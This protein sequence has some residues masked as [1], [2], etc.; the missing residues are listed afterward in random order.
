M[1]DDEPTG[2]IATG[3]IVAA[4][5]SITGDRETS[6]DIDYIA[7]YLIEGGS[8]V[9]DLLGRN[10][11][12]GTLY[13]PYLYGIYDA[14]G[15][16]VANH[17]DDG[18]IGFN[19]RI[20]FVAPETGTYYVAAGAY[21]TRTGTYTLSVSINPPVPE[22]HLADATEGTIDIGGSVTGDRETTT[23]S[24]FY[25]VNLAAGVTYSFDLEGYYTGAGT[26]RDPYIFGIYD[27][28]G[29]RIS[30]SDDDSGVGLNS[31]LLFTPSET[32]I[33]SISVGGYYYY[34]GTYTLSVDYVLPK[35]GDPFSEEPLL[36][37]G[38]SGDD[39]LVGAGNA[40]TIDG[41]DG[42][43]SLFG[44]AGGDILH[45]GNGADMLA[46]G[47]GDDILRGGSGNDILDG[48]YGN[49]LLGGGAGDDSLVSFGGTNTMW[50]GGGDDQAT[51]G[52]DDDIIG[53]GAGDDILSG[54]LRNDTLYGGAGDDSLLGGDGKDALYGGQGND[55]L[56]G[57]NDDDTLWGSMGN[58][59]LTGGDG[60]DTFVFT[61]GSGLD[62]ITDFDAENDVLML[63][64]TATDFLK[65]EDIAAVTVSFA[66]GLMINLGGGDAVFLA[67]VSLGDLETMTLEL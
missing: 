5:G 29:N 57:G 52:R 19:S 53:G 64:G 8:Y 24:D 49:D 22:E 28:A 26:L 1:P 31:R 10:T 15:T 62:I 2:S 37:L 6:N 55:T 7:V 17:D 36:I 27:S 66:G 33:Y 41:G 63:E 39:S 13:D 56:S 38:S 42:N 11:G 60:T 4:G 23:D 54:G 50:A 65:L 59:T 45:G 18:G 67:G 3:R 44:F 43:D 21:Y 14:T 30:P 12:D 40:D 47:Y 20:D 58:D 46:G 32:G 48:G 35:V 9:F 34:T 61:A 25:S 16:R 51:G